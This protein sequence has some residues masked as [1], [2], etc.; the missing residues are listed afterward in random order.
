MSARSVAWRSWTSFLGGRQ[1]NLTRTAGRSRDGYTLRQRF[2]ASFIGL[3][4][5]PLRYGLAPTSEA[6]TLI[7]SPPP[8]KPR[9]QGPSASRLP[10]GW[11]AL[12]ALLEVGGL[13]AA[14]SDTVV[15]EAS[16][17][18]GAARFLVRSTGAI[19]PAYDLELVLRGVDATLPLVSAVRYTGASGNQ[20]VLLVPVVQGRLGSPA[21]LVRLPDFTADSAARWTA[22]A[23]A[24]VTSSVAWD[25][26][27]VASSV[28][29]ALNEAT[30]EGWRQVRELVGDDLR[31]VIDGELI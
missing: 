20:Q 6:S 2:W 25:A 5:P 11:F 7:A 4:L 18:D 17:P 21:S 15:L 31:S 19:V 24:L 9:R 23:P 14:G 26:A 8:R 27:T 13:A 29:A 10:P 3:A 22:S 28:R 1:P 12:P 30:R 16:S